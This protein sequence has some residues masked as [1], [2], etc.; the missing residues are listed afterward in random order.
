MT[1]VEGQVWGRQAAQGSEKAVSLLRHL[2]AAREGHAS[3]VPFR[4]AG[5]EMCV[6]LESGVHYF[7]QMQ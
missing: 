6:F 1:H 3:G 4:V 2:V 7:R 5:M